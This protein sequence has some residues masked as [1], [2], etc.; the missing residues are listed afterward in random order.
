MRRNILVGAFLLIARFPCIEEPSMEVVCTTAAKLEA[1]FLSLFYKMNNHCNGLI[2]LF[3]CLPY[4]FIV[5]MSI[6]LEV[7]CCIY[8]SVCRTRI[9]ELPIRHVVASMKRMFALQFLLLCVFLYF[10]GPPV[11]CLDFIPISPLQ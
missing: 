7:C 5:V 8:Q 10:F 11:A 9:L 1:C 3:L 2:F 4:S 6:S